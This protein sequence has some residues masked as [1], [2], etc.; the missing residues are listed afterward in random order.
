MTE[1]QRN[2]EIEDII[3]RAKQC[4]HK[5]RLYA[6]EQFKTELRRLDL[7]PIEYGAACREIADALEV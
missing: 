6:Y 2:K 1:T 7:S 3:A 4:P 5:G